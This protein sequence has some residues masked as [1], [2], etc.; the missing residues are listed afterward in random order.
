VSIPEAT[1]HKVAVIKD[2]LHLYPNTPPLPDTD[3]AVVYRR[4]L[5]DLT[6]GCEPEDIVRKQVLD[7][8]C[9][10]DPRSLEIEHFGKADADELAE[11]VANALLPR[12]LKLFARHRWLSS[13]ETLRESC[14]LLGWHGIF[15]RAVPRWLAAQRAKTAVAPPGQDDQDWSMAPSG[16]G[17]HEGGRGGASSW[18]ED[19]EK[20]R[21]TLESWIESNPR[22]RI[23]TKLITVGPQV[24]LLHR[25]FAVAGEGWDDAQLAAVL[26]G[27]SRKFRRGGIFHNK[28]PNTFV[29]S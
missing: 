21:H 11:A 17:T 2:S 3:P 29:L 26:R 1:I 19:N 7:Q 22:Q 12:G 5:L 24:R 27:G 28:P 10:S 20:Q 25:C 14:L 23:L 4:R 16:S 8:Y 9:N 13:D 6:L 18:A 15:E